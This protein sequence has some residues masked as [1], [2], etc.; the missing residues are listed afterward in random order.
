MVLRRDGKYDT[1][2]SKP[3]KNIMRQDHVE[4]SVKVIEASMRHGSGP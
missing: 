1:Y 4:L 3:D 2:A